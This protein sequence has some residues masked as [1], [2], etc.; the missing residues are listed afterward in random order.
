MR[1]NKRRMKPHYV[2]KRIVKKNNEGASY[3]EY[4]VPLSFMAESWP[5]SG[6]IMTELYGERLNYIMNMVCDPCNITEGDGICVDVA[7]DQQ[8]DYKVIAI[9]KYQD[10][11]YPH[12]EC[13]LEKL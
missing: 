9:R 11:R 1:L 7:A 8:P 12:F 10:D 2:K 6:H 13:D 4:D 5:A 3:I